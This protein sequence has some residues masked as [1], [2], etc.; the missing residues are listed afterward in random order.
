M[1][2]FRSTFA[3]GSTRRSKSA[4]RT[5]QFWRGSH[6]GSDPWSD[7]GSDPRSDPGSDPCVL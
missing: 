1:T 3:Y 6:P 5:R 4:R 7:P 2:L